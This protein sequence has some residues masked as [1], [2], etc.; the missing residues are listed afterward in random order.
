MFPVAPDE[1]DRVQA[2]HAL[3]ILDTAPEAH[4][5]AL[6]RTAGALFR[7]PI[8]LVSLVGEDRQWFKARCGLDVDGTAREVAFCAY[9][10]LADEVF[11]VE[12]ALRDP[13]FAASPL[14]T[15]HGI[16]FYAGAPLVLGPGLQVGS[17]CVMDTVPRT[18]GP[19][20]IRQLRDLAAVVVAQL[21]LH[22]TEQDLREREERL[23]LALQAGR[24]VAWERDL[25][26]GHATRSDNAPELLGIGSGPI[27][28]M[29]DRV[30][31]DD[32]A[33]VERFSAYGGT[34]DAVEFRYRAPEGRLL[35]L[36]MR[37]E[38]TEPDRVVGITFDISDRKV[39]EAR[40]WRAANH[41]PLTG[42]PN[43]ALF[44]ERFR[45]ALAQ[46]ERSGTRVG[47]LLIDIDDFKDVNDTL[48]HDAGDA[49]LT[50]MAARL[51]EMARVGDT[52]AR[53]GGDEFAVILAGSQ[54]L[55]AASVFAGNLLERLRQPFAYRG[56]P[57]ATKA[58][59]GLA[60]FPDHHRLPD[61][62][63]KDADI[64]LYRAKASGRNRVTVYAP[65]M[66][67]LTERRVTVSAQMR[68]ALLSGQI[69]PFY[70]PKVC[71][72]TG[73]I[74]GFEALARWLHPTEG[75]LAPGYFG[76][77]FEDPELA[78]AIGGRIV[79][80]VAADIRAWRARGLDV[81]RVA[82]NV[83]SAEFHRPDLAETVLATLAAEGVPPTCLE[84]EVTETVFL[85]RGS[86]FVSGILRRF[87][88]SGVTLALDDF[89]TGYAS[90]T[91][92]KQF[93]VDHIKIDQSF[94][95]GL[96]QD[97]DDA[98]I[99]AAV[100]GLGRA[101]GTRVTAEGVENPEQVRR[102]RA[103]GCGFAQ[104]Y[105]YAKPMA[106]SRVPWLIANGPALGG[107]APD[108]PQAGRRIAG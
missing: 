75:V 40:L 35:W 74:V 101:L 18:F 86:D 88:D 10:I 80:Q 22:R 95:R 72:E 14:V 92:L 5:D 36:C 30:H 90:L 13:R 106:G 9:A 55:E 24:M 60:S 42:L 16:R 27:S 26:T 93:P 64:A 57:L 73:R 102:L 52:V 89:G 65:E 99:V 4:F 53:L 107:R 38:Q 1:A 97:G 44:Q 82:V 3:R 46:A 62:L 19:D 37:A 68:E 6:C 84:I 66:R 33:H 79:A 31:P 69:V 78:H 59:M 48:G 94:V 29:L 49:L 50:E 17:L 98:A 96:E 39:G 15:E 100:I 54:R 12:D 77:A 61:E 8:A 103:M 56:R 47:L 51:A 83:S 71:L 41:D 85:G 45:E 43:R 28:L 76:S 25:R 108:E 104:G 7:A 70:Q 21:R 87:H 34:L 91:H 58:S 105:L 67:A 2:L 32:R 20:E 23:R 81:G 63:M 11:I